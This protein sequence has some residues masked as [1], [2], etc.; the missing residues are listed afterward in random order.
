MSAKGVPA[1]F[2]WTTRAPDRARGTSPEPSITDGAGPQALDSAHGR[3]AAFPTGEIE[4]SWSTPEKAGS[5]RMQER[6][7]SAT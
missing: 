1:E 3:V 7:L 5:S 6:S 2:H 4:H